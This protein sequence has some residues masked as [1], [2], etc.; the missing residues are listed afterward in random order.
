MRFMVMIFENLSSTTHFEVNLQNIVQ[1]L[2]NYRGLTYTTVI[3]SYS[4]NKQ[5]VIQLFYFA[6]MLY[7]FP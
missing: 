3:F 4:I 1:Y 6:S 5:F 7:H 2:I